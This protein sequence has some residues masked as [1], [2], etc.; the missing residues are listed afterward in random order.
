MSWKRRL[1]GSVFVAGLGVLSP[2]TR[3]EDPAPPK[4]DA[5]ATPAEAPKKKDPFFGDRFAMYLET[6]GGP[7]S[8]DE[9]DNSLSSGV[10]SNSLNSL[11]FDGRKSGQFTVGWTLPRGRG[12][13]LLTFT[14]FDDGDYEL[15]GTGTQ[16]TY[17]TQ[18]G[19]QPITIG[20]QLPWWQVSVRDGQLSAT[21]TPPVWNASLD[22]ANGN[23]RPDPDEMRYPVTT[24]SIAANYPT[25]LGNRI[26]TWDLYYRREFGGVR[27]RSRW[28]AG[29]RYLKFDGAIATPA[30]VT[31]AS[32]AAGFGYTDGSQTDFILMKQSTTG[33]G[34][35]GSGEVDFNFFRQRLTLYALVQ[36]A[37]LME[38]LETDSGTFTYYSVA[39]GSTGYLPGPGHLEESVSKSAWN[40]T[41]EAGLRV[42]ILEG[43]NLILDW[44]ATGYL[45]TMLLPTQVSI[46]DN[47]TQILLGTTGRFVS[48]DF[49]I[50]S[51]NL[52]LSFEF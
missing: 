15:E 12:Q 41:F 49:V 40:T 30:W 1:V 10:K 45:D 16:S 36:A 51:I 48:R 11:N 42:K 44:N 26:Q 23:A 34:P 28:T 46:P 21:K 19:G 22:D 50:Q 33:F 29:V 6:R 24:V 14:G 4:P 17:V 20:F 31:G 9:V 47:A 37:F 2:G 27:I 5:T 13:Y 18:G 43:F 8:V 38:N 35:V 39:S 52:G 7:A 3:A 32:S 25:D